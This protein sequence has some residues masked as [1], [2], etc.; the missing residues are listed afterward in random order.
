MSI[1]LSTDEFE[2]HRLRFSDYG[3]AVWQ[4]LFLL[5]RIDWGKGIKQ[6]LA[7]MVGYVQVGTSRTVGSGEAGG[8][9]TSRTLV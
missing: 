1:I 9:D 6:V 3:L 2:S 5:P 7:S 8:D 4:V